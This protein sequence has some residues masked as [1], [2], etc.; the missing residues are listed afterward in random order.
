[1]FPFQAHVYKTGS[2]TCAAFLANVGTQ[3]DASVNFN[4]NTYHLPAWSVSILPD[5]KNVVFNTA[6][7]SLCQLV[8]AHIWAFDPKV[9]SFIISLKWF[10]FVIECVYLSICSIYIS[11]CIFFRTFTGNNELPIGGK[12]CLLSLSYPSEGSYR[13]FPVEAFI[14]STWN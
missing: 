11:S 6:K 5:C 2:G 1:M 3:S 9:A 10:Y 7:V 14:S 4:G 13:L 12:C 8:F